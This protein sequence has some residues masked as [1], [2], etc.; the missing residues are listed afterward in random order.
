MATYLNLYTNNPTAAGTDGTVISL[1]GAQTA[2]VSVT[3]DAAKAESKIVKCAIRC[4]AGYKTTG[5]TVISFT[6]TNAGKWSIADDAN[7]SDATAAAA[8]T[9]AS[10]LTISN[11]I[12]K[13]NKIFWLKAVSSSDENPTSD[14]SVS[15]NVQTIVQAE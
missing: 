14:T 1:S 6:G 10:S 15:I 9:Y 12:G 11:E 3:L 7:Y 5:N 13:T 2:P 8:G 4:E